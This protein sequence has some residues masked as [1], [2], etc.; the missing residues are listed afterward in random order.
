MTSNNTNDMVYQCDYSSKWSQS[1]TT[2]NWVLFRFERKVTKAEWRVSTGR[3]RQDE[4]ISPS[5]TQRLFE[6]AGIIQRND[7]ACEEANL[8]EV[9]WSCLR[10]ESSV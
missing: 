7:T 2:K 10:P 5:R 6:A 8:A 3:V 9:Q 1:A 4:G